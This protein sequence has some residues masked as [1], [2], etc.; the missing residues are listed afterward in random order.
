MLVFLPAAT[1]GCWEVLEQ[2][3]LFAV[4]QNLRL[5]C[6]FDSSLRFVVFR[7][8]TSSTVDQAPTFRI[9]TK[10]CRAGHPEYLCSNRFPQPELRP[11]VKNSKSWCSVKFPY[12]EFKAKMLRIRIKRSCRGSNHQ[13]GRLTQINLFLQSHLQQTFPN[14]RKQ[15]LLACVILL[16]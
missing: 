15:F 4:T 12:P 14:E 5:C 3:S 8:R 6:V 1:S 16:T 11:G 9:L 7:L 10:L 2:V 13:L